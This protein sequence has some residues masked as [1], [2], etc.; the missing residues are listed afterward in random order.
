MVGRPVRRAAEEDV[1]S[2][3]QFGPQA[4]WPPGQEGVRLAFVSAEVFDK[5]DADC[6]Q[7]VLVTFAETAVDELQQ[8]IR[9]PR[10]PL[11]ETCS[12]SAAARRS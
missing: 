2:F 12:P 11:G 4:W 5:R 1:R 3:P 10:S 9:D 7:D 8:T 6:V